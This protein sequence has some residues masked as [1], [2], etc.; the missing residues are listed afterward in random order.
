MSVH[1]VLSMDGFKS[2]ITDSSPYSCWLVFIML[3]N[4][5]PNKC[6]KQEFIFLAL[7]ISNPKE[8]KKQMN[9]F[10][11]FIDRRA[12]RTMTKGRCI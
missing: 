4:L 5:L 11:Y 2:H 9:I 3:Y 12:E 1:L 8:P 7:V 6:L 10:L